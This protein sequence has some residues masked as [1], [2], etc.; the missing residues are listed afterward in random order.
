MRKTALI[1]L[2]FI[3]QIAFSQNSWPFFYFKFDTD[4]SN[5]EYLSFLNDVEDKLLIR[6]DSSNC[7]Q[8]LKM[9]ATHFRM[10]YTCSEMHYVYLDKA[11]LKRRQPTYQT[12]II[13]NNAVD[14]FKIVGFSREYEIHPFRVDKVIVDTLLTDKEVLKLLKER[15]T[16]VFDLEEQ[17]KYR[18]DT[19]YL[20]KYSSPL[21]SV[22]LGNYDVFLKPSTITRLKSIVQEAVFDHFNIKKYDSL[23]LRETVLPLDA[24]NILAQASL[25]FFA[26]YIEG[27]FWNM[28]LYTDVALT[29][30][31]N[32]NLYETTM[33]VVW[34]STNSVED[35][36]NPVV[37]I[38]APIKKEF[39]PVAIHIVE[40]WRD[41]PTGENS[42]FNY[43]FPLINLTRL[44]YAIG[45]ELSSNKI[46]YFNYNEIK[47][48]CKKENLNFEPYNQLFIGACTQKLNLQTY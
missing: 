45:I 36:Y 10:E 23:L 33:R 1:F 20:G 40:A 25:P 18:N 47:E 19:V 13:P 9:S 16:S 17:Y 3:S 29:K 6:V 41:I 22:P 11:A 34:D 14:T 38:S 42:H 7:N 24:G 48:F 15:N 4:Y 8:S 32:N 5:T 39:H 2:V 28:K 26:E 12:F 30:G 37:F 35:P 46:V 21:F 44:N 31:I 27:H 43:P